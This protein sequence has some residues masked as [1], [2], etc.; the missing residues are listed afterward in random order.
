MA[1]A[2]ATSVIMGLLDDVLQLVSKLPPGALALLSKLMRTLL[3]SKDPVSAL[4]RATLAAASEQASE[5][6]LKKLLGRRR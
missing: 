4:R 5:E 6:A 2:I 3:A 1:Y